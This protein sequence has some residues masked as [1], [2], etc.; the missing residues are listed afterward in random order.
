MKNLIYLFLGALLVISC[1]TDPC[2]DV[3]C[4]TYGACSEGVCICDTGYEQ[5]ADDQCNTEV[6]AKFIKSGWT[7]SE[8]CTS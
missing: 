5:D 1:N 6:R 8:S 7:A 3:V 2:K 4:G